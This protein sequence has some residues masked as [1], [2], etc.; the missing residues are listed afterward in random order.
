MSVRASHLLIKHTDSR[1]P[2]SRRTNTQVTLSKSDALKEM[3]NLYG[4]LN[5]ENFAEEATKR[6]DCSSYK[7]GGDLGVFTRGQMQKPFED[8]AFGL[9]VGEMSGIVE[10]DSGIHV[11]LRTG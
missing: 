3:Q 1:N 4:K 10:T 2:I 9:K 11:I 8:A 7:N 6:S 5:K